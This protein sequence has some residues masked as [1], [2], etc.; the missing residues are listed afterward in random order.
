MAMFG[1][2]NTL[3]HSVRMIAMHYPPSG[4]GFGDGLTEKERAFVQKLA[5]EIYE[6]GE[7]LR[8]LG[9]RFRG[10]KT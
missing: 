8:K 2:C 4:V 10:V 3:A 7:V 1:I 6:N 9:W 5:G